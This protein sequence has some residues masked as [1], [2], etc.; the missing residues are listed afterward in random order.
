MER[1]EELYN[2]ITATKRPSLVIES[3]VEANGYKFARPMKL[4]SETSYVTNSNDVNASN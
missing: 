2:E 3:D 4:K 1:A